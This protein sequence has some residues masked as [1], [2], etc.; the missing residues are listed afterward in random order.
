LVGFCSNF[1]GVGVLMWALVFGLGY[2]GFIVGRRVQ[3][4]RCSSCEHWVK[5]SS[6]RCG[7]CNTRLVGEIETQAD[8]MDAEERY[9]AERHAE[10]DAAPASEA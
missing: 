6:T 1:A 10:P 5:P 7:F 3:A 4:S 9:F 8:R 2:V